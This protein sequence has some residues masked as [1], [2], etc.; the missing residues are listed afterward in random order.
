MPN[1]LITGITGQDGAYL[2]R[3]LLRRGYQVYGTVR[4]ATPAATSSLRALGVEEQVQL[5]PTDFS[6]SAMLAHALEQAA[7]DEIYHLAAQSSVALSWQQPV[8]TGEITGLGTARLLQ[9]WRQVCPAARFF[10]A[11]SSEMYGQVAVAPQ[12]ETTPFQPHSPYG[13]AKLYA[14]WMTVGYRETQAAHASC[15]ILFNHES[16]LRPE[17][18][19]TRKVTRAAARIKHGLQTELVLGNLETQRDWGFAGDY[20]AAMWRILQHEQPDDY[21]IATGQIHSLREFVDLAFA[22]VGLNYQDYVRTDPAF[23]R[24]AEAIALVGDPHKI[25]TRLGWAPRVGFE[26]LVTLL[27]EADLKRVRDEDAMIRYT[28]ED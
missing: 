27:V 17:A 19:V 22:Q 20:V 3:F 4:S 12:T 7:P 16:P 13:A 14:H 10:Q 28:L 24:P 1:A 23:F 25:A 21:V 5:I 2:A 9:A 15:G 11:S 18:F 26:Q 6:V 8:A